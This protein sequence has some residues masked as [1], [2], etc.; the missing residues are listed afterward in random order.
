MNAWLTLW[1]DTAQQART[2]GVI[3]RRRDHVDRNTSMAT[4]INEARRRGWHVIETGDQVVVL[5]HEGDIRL[6]C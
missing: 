1:F 3:R 4:V 2:G 5:C 6:H